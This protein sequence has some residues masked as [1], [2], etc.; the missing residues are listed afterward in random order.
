MAVILLLAVE[1]SQRDEAF[2][3]QQKLLLYHSPRKKKASPAFEQI[4]VCSPNTNMSGVM[5]E[6]FL[7][8]DLMPQK[9][10]DMENALKSFLSKHDDHSKEDVRKRIQKM[11][12][13]KIHEHKKKPDI[14]QA[15]DASAVR[16]GLSDELCVNFD[17][18]LCAAIDDMCGVMKA[19]KPSADI[20]WCTEAADFCKLAED[21]HPELKAAIDAKMCTQ[22]RTSIPACAAAQQVCS[23]SKELS[24]G[25]FCSRISQLC[26]R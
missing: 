16:I 3:S 21:K 20:R 2:M 5:P 19:Y 11:V 24:G 26:A 1:R 7:A 23:S 6:N 25:T 15:F 18:P 14:G 17:T 10:E 12:H 9:V 4:W 22:F 13:D 8:P